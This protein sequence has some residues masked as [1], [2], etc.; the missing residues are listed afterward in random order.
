MKTAVLQ[1]FSMKNRK[2]QSK[3]T[4]FVTGSYFF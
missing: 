2:S 3:I 4:G 1:D